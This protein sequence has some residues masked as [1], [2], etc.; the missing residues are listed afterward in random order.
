MNITPHFQFLKLRNSYP[1][2]IHNT[3]Q[4]GSS[5]AGIRPG[6]LFQEI[7]SVGI[8]ESSDRTFRL[9]HQ[10]RND[11]EIVDGTEKF[12]HIPK[13]TI[14]VDL[15]QKGLSQPFRV[16]LILLA[17]AIQNRLSVPYNL[18]LVDYRSLPVILV[19]SKLIFPNGGCVRIADAHLDSD[20]RI[21]PGSQASK[22]RYTPP[23][24]HGFLETASYGHDI[25]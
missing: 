16:L 14:N 24:S 23:L 13:R 11:M 8:V 9:P 10:L 18:F 2:R 4:S 22:F 21:A 15:F 3:S 17:G 20:V 25:A 19:K 1:Q 12:R 5:G 7:S 6:D